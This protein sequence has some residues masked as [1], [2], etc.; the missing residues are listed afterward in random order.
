M[1]LLHN[2]EFEIINTVFQ[3][4]LIKDINMINKDQLLFIPAN[5]SIN[6]IQVSKDTYSKLLKTTSQ[7]RTKNLTS[8]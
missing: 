7:N 4:Q 8:L 5:K 6:L 1:H 2:I 3:N